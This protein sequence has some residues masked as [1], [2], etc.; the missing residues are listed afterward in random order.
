MSV[1][2]PQATRLRVLAS[3]LGVAQL[4][5]W[6]TLYYAIAVLGV[7]MQKELGLSS[8]ELFASFTGSLALSGLLAPWAGRK[9][10]RW[11]GRAA[12]TAGMLLGA[13]GFIVL[14]LAQSA[15]ML[16]LGFAIHGVA[17]ALALYDTCFAA[18]GQAVPLSYRPTVTA[19]TLIAGLASTVFWPLSHYLEASL[20]WRVTCGVYAAM[21]VACA[22]LYWAVLP[23]HVRSSDASPGTSEPGVEVSA[24]LR[25]RARAL[26]FAFAGAA[27]VSAALSA[28]LV[29]T[30]REFRFSS[31][32][33]VWIASSIGVMQ[34]AG[35]LTELRGPRISAQRLSVLTFSGLLASLLFLMAS[36]AVP[37]A[38]VLFAVSYG[39]A[40]GVMTIVKAVLPVEIFGTR[41]VGAVLGRFSAPSLVAR[42][43]APWAFAAGHDGPLGTMGTLG[44][45]GLVAL[46][47][48]LTCC[49]YARRHAGAASIPRSQRGVESAY[50]R[51]ATCGTSVRW[52][53][54]RPD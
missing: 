35:R 48:L 38:I 29:T 37:L 8:A 53:S 12:L 3:A 32:Q 28:H 18:I 54:R 15:W 33:A 52:S 11:G 24:S 25:A 27:L 45:T 43:A 5:A 46:A 47:A 30:L 22:P 2:V 39:V 13:A 23:R 36:H 51:A 1:S 17:M 49:V 4:V 20:G 14:A 34:V 21:L 19:V 31:E 50:S 9:L 6:G 7:P 10:D 26:S 44:V 40:N 16:T 41:E 42:A